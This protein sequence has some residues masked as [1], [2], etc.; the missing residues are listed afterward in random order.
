MRDADDTAHALG[1]GVEIRVAQETAHKCGD[2]GRLEKTYISRKESGITLLAQENENL[3]V[4]HPLA[5][6]VDTDL[7]RRQ[8][9][10]FQEQALSLENI[11]VEDD[12]SSGSFEYVFRRCVFSGV[13]AE[14][15]AREPNRFRYGIR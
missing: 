13:V 2:F 15:L 12:Q 5:S 6:K 11:L 7:P 14:R 4:F 10:C 9:R 3:I 1:L 8:P